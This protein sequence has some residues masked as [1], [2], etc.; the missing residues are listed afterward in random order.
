MAGSLGNSRK[1]VAGA[2]AVELAVVLPVLLML[3]LPVVDFAR[4][5]QAELILASI[6]REGAS[7]ASRSGMPP[8]NILSALAATSPP[9]DMPGKGMIYITKIM[10]HQEGGGVRSVVL[11]QH[12]WAQG[13]RQSA[14]SPASAIW[15][16]GSGGTS[17]A[18]GTD[19]GGSCQGLP[20][21]SNASPTANVM[22]GK[23]A[24]GELV[25]AVEAFYRFSG[26]F[27]GLDVGFGAVPRLGPDLYS[28]AIF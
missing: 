6:S 22:P 27:G 10:G 12:R 2:A 11:E 9:L 1:R 7:L 23:L 4:A 25:Y 8:Q 28:M 19:A 24:D 21:A 16:C 20:G 17:W 18:T 26:L 5:I 3:A 13:W 14:Y 15:N